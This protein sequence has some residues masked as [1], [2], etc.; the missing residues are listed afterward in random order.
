MVW[1]L[2]AVITALVS[3]TFAVLGLNAASK[4]RQLASK[5]DASVYAPYPVTLRSLIPLIIILAIASV[6]SFWKLGSTKVPSSTAEFTAEQPVITEFT[7]LPNNVTRIL[8]YAAINTG[9]EYHVG[10]YIVSYSDDGNTW[11]PLTVWK[12]DYA[13]V[14]KWHDSDAIPPDDARFLKIEASRPGLEL[15]EVVFFDSAER[16]IPFT[17]TNPALCDEQTLPA[18]PDDWMYNSYFDEVYHPRTAVEH[19]RGIKP[20]EV[21]H[22]PLGKLIMSLGIKI[23][24]I[25]PLGWRIIGVIIG[26]LTIIPLYIFIQNLFGKT[27]V[28][29]SATILYAFD[30]MRYVQTR[31]ATVDTEAV[32]FILLMYYFMYRAISEPSG[33]SLKMT[34]TWLALSGLSF[35]L[36]AATKWI[37][38]YG[39]L[40]LIVLWIILAVKIRK[41]E[42][43]TEK[44]GLSKTSKLVM[45]SI[46]FFIAVPVTIY[47]LSY[48]PYAIAKYGAGADGTFY[49]FLKMV[50]ENQKYM[51]TYHSGLDSTHPYSSEWWQWLLNLRPILYYRT[52][53]DV[54]RISEFGAFASPLVAW[55]GLLSLALML[56]FGLRG[57]GGHVI[58]LG[59]FSQLLPW[60]IVPRITF[61]YHYFPNIVFLIP[62]I[63]YVMDKLADSGWRHYKLV[64]GGFAALGIALFVLFFPV[65]SGLPVNN[66]YTDW[67]SWFGSYPF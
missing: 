19:L 43:K 41:Y 30:F 33:T 50:F 13:S 34:L 61:A 27:F 67:L 59:Y 45:C 7:S 58:A 64:I 37:V 10:E 29:A 17:S 16:L 51:L 63:A 35:G 31:L 23:F 39:G 26:L 65:L 57:N 44:T 12:Q 38:V 62:A 18:T 36:G 48:I 47:L 49:G 60:V 54:G 5:P 32:F 6:L 24:G 22:P 3:V 28:S 21:T 2:P 11:Y 46:V 56:V 9:T 52:Y 15:G 14:F 25:N 66:G 40:G 55:A 1:I 4:Q 42:N 20:Y 53:P 8:W